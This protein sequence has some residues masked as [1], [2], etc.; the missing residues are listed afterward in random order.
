VAGTWKQFGDD[1]DEAGREIFVEE[2][3]HVVMNSKRRSPSAANAR[4]ARKSS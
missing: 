3:L 2:Q 4:Q 1:R